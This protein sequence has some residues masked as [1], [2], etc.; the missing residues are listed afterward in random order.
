MNILQKVLISLNLLVFSA[1]LSCKDEVK[2]REPEINN[3]WNGYDFSKEQLK[4]LKALAENGDVDAAWKME[5]YYSAIEYN[6]ELSEYYRKLKEN[7]H[8]KE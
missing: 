2:Q 4:E 3:P 5:I 1:V 8:E 6:E 7:Y